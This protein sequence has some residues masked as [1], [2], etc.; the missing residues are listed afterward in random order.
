MQII[1][2]AMEL[3][4]I[5]EYSIMNNSIETIMSMPIIDIRIIVTNMV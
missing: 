5:N 3:D 2:L 1:T 4:K